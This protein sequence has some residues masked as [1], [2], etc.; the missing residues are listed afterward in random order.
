[1]LTPIFLQVDGG[2]VGHLLRERLPVGVDLLDGQRAED[3]PQ[4][5]LERLED[6]A[7]DLLGRH[8]EEAL[9]R[10][11]QRDV[12]AGDLDVGDRLDRDGDA[13]LRVGALDLAAGSR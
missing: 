4:V 6:D 12:V 8:A 3:R 5:P 1:M 2:L 9:G 10:A 7:L 13:F 11:A